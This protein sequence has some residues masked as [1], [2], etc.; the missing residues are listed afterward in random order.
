M[1]SNSPRNQHHRNT[2]N[3]NTETKTR[4]SNFQLF[5]DACRYNSGSHFLD[6]GGAYGRH[7]QKPAIEEKTFSATLDVW[8][9]E[10]TGTIETAHFLDSHLKVDRD[11]QTQFEE[12]AADREGDWFSL[13]V[14]FAE[15]VLGMTQR[16]RDNVYNGENDLTQVYIWEVYTPEDDDSRDWLYADDA[17]T[18]IFV[19]TGC[20]V[21]GGY[22]APLFCRGKGEYV[23]PVD[24][25]AEFYAI[26]ARDGDGDEI[27][28]QDIGEKWRSGWSSWPAGQLRDDVKRVFHFTKTATTVCALLNS[29]EVVKIGVEAPGCY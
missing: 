11:I 17:L 29:G 1:P 13:S 20:D 19:H 7:W 3:M 12:W 28:T 4:K 18:V 22:S 6:S 21:R 14:E 16:A 2:E 26:E 27:E 15:D 25:C 5:A 23:I 24:V 9:N 8:R 10:I